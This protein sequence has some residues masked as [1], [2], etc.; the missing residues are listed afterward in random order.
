M[1]PTEA[2]L[3][4]DL[5]STPNPVYK[6]NNISVYSI[7]ILPTPSSELH[8]ESS[9]SSSKRKRVDSPVS[10]AKRARAPSTSQSNTLQALMNQQ[11]FSPG[12]LEGEFAQE[13]RRQMLQTMFP[14][15]REP[16]EIQGSSKVEKRR[17]A[18]EAA[19]ETPATP[20]VN[21]ATTSVCQKTL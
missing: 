19:K 10:F 17:A 12:L 4:P 5:S 1:Y 11:D 8:V 18:K 15:S 2:P 9:E 3:V 13:W 6:D 14:K 20:L 21:A 16:E 7:P